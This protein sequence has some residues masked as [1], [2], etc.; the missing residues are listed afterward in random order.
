MK[1]K[2]FLGEDT[3]SDCDDKVIRAGQQ[4]WIDRVA[5]VGN[6]RSTFLDT[7]QERIQAFSNRHAKMIQIYC[8]GKKVLEIG[9][10][11]GRMLKAFSGV[12]SYLGVDFVPDLIKEAK[13]RA[14]V[15][16]DGDERF[17][18]GILNVREPLDIEDRFDVIV[19]ITTL[20]SLQH[21]YWELLKN[22][23]SVLRTHGKILWLEEIYDRIDY[24]D[25]SG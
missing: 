24:V 13:E 11:W 15:L 3:L 18:F 8:T 5:Q 17:S 14:E 9:C 22:L 7:P 23:K 20:S 6:H 2:P 4:Y 19:A 12:Q 1:E 16:Y 25:Y 21:D 10:G